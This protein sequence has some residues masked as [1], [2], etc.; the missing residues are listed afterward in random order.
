VTAR[1]PTPPVD[2]FA[3][4]ELVQT[5]MATPMAALA[6][7]V[8]LLEL[9]DEAPKTIDEVAGL[10]QVTSRAAEAMVAVVAALKFL[11]PVG[12]GRFT[13]TALGRTYLMAASPFRRQMCPPA[14]PALARL[15]QAFR[16]TEPPVPLAVSMGTLPPDRVRAFIDQMH[17]VTLPAADSLSRLPIF[18]RLRSLLDVGAGS[19]SL[20][21]GIAARHPGIRCTLLDLPQVCAIAAE[22]VAAYGLEDRITIVP[23]DMFRDAWPSGHDAVLFGNIFHDWD[24]A[25]CVTLAAKAS[26]VLGPGGVILLHEAPLDDEKDGPLTVACFSVSMLLHE[27]GKQYT[28]RELKD[29]LTEAGFVDFD[30][31]VSHGDHHLISARKP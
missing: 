2:D 1:F 4:T 13:P 3:I 28:R 5:R 22:H 30:S 31:T 14:D 10:L 11:A 29:V 26:S 16:Q 20:A 15:R 25:T 12:G 6:Q 19:G 24:R 17:A 7:E 23:A 8:G 9:L 27:R 18:T 21:S